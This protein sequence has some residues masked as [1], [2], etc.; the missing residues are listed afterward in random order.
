MGKF[1]NEMS[2]KKYPSE[3][4]GHPHTSLGNKAADDRKRHWCPFVN[5]ICYK[6]S[7]LI[8]YPFGVCS[9]QVSGHDIALCPRR[10]LDGH[11]VFSD[12]AK[13]HFKTVSDILV[14]P[15]VHLPDVGSFDFVMLKHKPLSTDIDD[16]I[17]IEFQTG[18]TTGTGDLVKGLKDFMA[19]QKMGDHSYNFGL[20]TYDIWKRTLTQILNKGV[21]LEKWG[22][23]IVWVI[24]DQ[25]FQNFEKRYNLQDLDYQNKHSTVFALYD[26]KEKANK[27]ELV[28]TRKVSA[29]M[30]RLFDS[31]RNNPDI[32]PVGTFIEKL[33]E[34]IK[35]AGQLSLKLE[36]K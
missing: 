30:D 26:L 31:M 22:K 1:D 19:G 23:K 27:F 11:I 33:Q 5:K 20:N 8:K 9:A 17:V 32:P 28:P 21:I 16:F 3:I 29:S 14:F 4:F 36:S 7:R 24:Q 18:Q 10:F 34:K 13:L 2:S 35:K 12:I 25:I 15:E 6:Q